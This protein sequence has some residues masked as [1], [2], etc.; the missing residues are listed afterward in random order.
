MSSHLIKNG[1][2]CNNKIC[3]ENLSKRIGSFL[4]QFGAKMNQ[5][6]KNSPN[7]NLETEKSLFSDSSSPGDITA[8]PKFTLENLRSSDSA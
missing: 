1:T 5:W 2:F 7:F 6:C 8:D 3:A 4:H